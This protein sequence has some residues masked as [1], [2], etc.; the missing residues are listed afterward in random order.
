MRLDSYL[1]ENDLAKSRTYAAELIKN[2]LVLVNNVSVNKPSFKVSFGDEVI[3]I[4]ELYDYVSRAAYKLKTAKE[5]FNF[6][7]DGK[8]VL[9]IGSSTGGFTDFCLEN[10]ASKVYAVDVGSNQLVDKLRNDSRVISL[11][12]CDIR[13]ITYQHL[14]EDIDFI[15]CDV[16]FISLTKII[17]KISDIAT[18][19]CDIILLFKPQFEVGAKNLNKQGVVKNKKSIITALA[20]FTDLIK[21][22]NLNIVGFKA[23][24][25]QGKSGNQE[26][27]M[28]LKKDSETNLNIEEMMSEL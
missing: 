4:A 6:S 26:Y 23:S 17:S 3:V 5:A 27:L 12:N 24:D 18:N 14:N 10:N 25:I 11:E 7:L 13:D 22:Y 15:C 21:N 19:S 8:V 16:S 9:D 1:F 20:L 2:N 28:Y